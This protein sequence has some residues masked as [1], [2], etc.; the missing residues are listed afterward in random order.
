MPNTIVGFATG[1][2]YFLDAEQQR[3]ASALLSESKLV[4]D[5]PLSRDNKGTPQCGGGTEDGMD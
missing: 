3:E 1:D 2:M 5:F 4:V